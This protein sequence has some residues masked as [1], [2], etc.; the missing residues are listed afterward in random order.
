MQEA[1]LL[2]RMI[3]HLQNYLHGSQEAQTD[4]CRQGSCYPLWGLCKNQKRQSFWAD[5][6]HGLASEDWAGYWP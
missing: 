3:F 1:Q 2:V 4:E 5:V 6:A